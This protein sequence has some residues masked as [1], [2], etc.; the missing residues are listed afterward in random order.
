[1][2]NNLNTHIDRI[3]YCIIIPVNITNIY[4]PNYERFI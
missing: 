2:R 3:N 1:M 4:K